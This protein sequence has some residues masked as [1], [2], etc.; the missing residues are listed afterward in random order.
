MTQRGAT[1]AVVLL[2]ACA[3]DKQ[4][5][6]P[7][8]ASRGPRH[9]VA[10][11]EVAAAEKVAALEPW[12]PYA[13]KQAKPAEEAKKVAED[14]RDYGA[15]L[16]AALGTP[17]NCL[18]TRVGSDAPTEIRISLE[19]SVVETG[20]VTRSDASSAQLDDGEI[21][22]VRGRLGGLR[23]RA[24]VSGAPRSVRATLELKRQAPAAKPAADAAAGDAPE[25]AP[26]K[27]PADP[28]EAPEAVRE[29]APREEAPREEPPREEPPREE[30]PPR[31]AD[32]EPRDDNPVE[33]P[34]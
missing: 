32:D 1:L 28:V 30:P 7:S 23:L 2:C 16:L 19:A 26:D 13:G 29:E 12:D 3:S 20:I 33:P 24:P 17:V 6:G 18:K 27:E 5:D 21:A 4:T 8:N 11:E 9:R 22:C 10:T 25:D 14:E 15:E 34:E 31:S